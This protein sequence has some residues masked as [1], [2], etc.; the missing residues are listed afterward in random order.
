MEATMPGVQKFDKVLR[1]S[2]VA[3]F[4]LYKTYQRNAQPR[5]S[6]D[7][8]GQN[9]QDRYWTT[10]YRDQPYALANMQ[11]VLQN[12]ITDWNTKSPSTELKC[13]VIDDTQ[14][15]PKTRFMFATED[16]NNANQRNYF[17]H[18]FLSDQD[19]RM[20]VLND[21]EAQLLL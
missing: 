14:A 4:R 11:R 2:L 16:P 12:I 18:F 19:Q 10:I 5:F 17:W 8:N 9:Q 6:G 13:G 15:P 21:L 7:V 1:I 20:F 3:R